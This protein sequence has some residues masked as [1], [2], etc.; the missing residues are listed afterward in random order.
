MGMQIMRCGGNPLS[1]DASSTVPVDHAN[2]LAH[3]STFFNYY[4]LFNGK[5]VFITVTFDTAADDDETPAE[6]SVAMGGEE[7]TS[8]SVCLDNQDTGGIFDC[9]NVGWL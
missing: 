9:V 1:G 7:R 3:A 6:C 8:S 2:S 4:E 5:E